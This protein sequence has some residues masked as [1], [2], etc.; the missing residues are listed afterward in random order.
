MPASPIRSV[1]SQPD[2]RIPHVCQVGTNTH[3]RIHGCVVERK[4]L[5]WGSDIPRSAHVNLYVAAVVSV[6]IHGH[7]GWLLSE[8]VL[9]SLKHFKKIQCQVSGQII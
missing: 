9:V 7:Q 1:V 5:I 2:Y 4:G 3:T 8:K 6:L